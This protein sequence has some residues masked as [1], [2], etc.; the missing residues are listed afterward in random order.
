MIDIIIPAYNAHKT[1]RRTLN[2]ISNQTIVDLIKVYII[3]DF[4]KKDYSAEIST[5]EKHIKIQELKL[6]KNLGPGSAR[7]YGIDNSNSKYIVFI[8]ADDIFAKQNSLEVLLKSI[9]ENNADV[10]ISNFYEEDEKGDYIEHNN[11]KIW[12]HGKIYKRSFL[13]KHNIK[14]NNSRA[15]EDNGF[16][17]LIFLHDSIVNTIEDYTYIWNYYANSITRKN[18]QEYNWNGLERIYL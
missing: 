9:E 17:Q 1:I 16:N 10:V 15:N 18:N 8:D 3:N 13:K 6:S 2:S 11:D 5:F 4:S 12:L 14:F 7:Q